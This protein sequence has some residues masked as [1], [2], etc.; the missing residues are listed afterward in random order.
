LL[1]VKVKLR[2][3]LVNRE[4]PRATPASLRI[5]LHYAR[6]GVVTRWDWDRYLRL[7]SFLDYTPAEL[8]SVICLEH[9]NL[10][11]CERRNRFPGTAAL[12]L[13]MLEARALKSYSTDI[14]EN[15]FPNDPPKG[16]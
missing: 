3:L 6:L 10:A 7:A 16:S 5:D 2:A 9:R 13:T 12:L 8:A 11:L 4:S 14:I 1:A 15:P